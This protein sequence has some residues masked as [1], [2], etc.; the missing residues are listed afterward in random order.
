MD[1]QKLLEKMS[2]EDK[3]AQMLQITPEM[4]T[5]KSEGMVTGPMT[6]F[7]IPENVTSRV[8]SVL[9]GT[10]AETLRELQKL[11]LKE[12]P[13]GIPLLFMADV[14]H[15]FRT[16][17]PTPLGI[18]ATFDEDLAEECSAMAAKE[19]AASGLHV[20]FAPMMDLARDARWGRC[21]ETCGE[22]PHLNSKMAAAMV[23]GFQGD[24]GSDRVAAC[25]KHFAAYSACEGGRDYD[26]AEVC[27]HT[28]REYYLPAYKAAIDA[29]VELAMTSF[30]TLNGVPSSANK[31]LVDG[32]LRKEWGFDGIVISDYGALREMMPHGISENEKESAQKALDATTDIE[33][34]TAC[35]VKYGKELLDEGKITLEQIDTAV[36]RILKLKEKLGL[37]D[38]PFRSSSPEEEKRLFLCKEH[39]DIAR[40]AAQKS[41]VLLKNEDVLPFDD[42]VKKVA[43]IGPFANRGMIGAWYC[44][45]REDEAVSVFEG[46]KKERPDAVFSLGCN[47]GLKE[48]SSDAKESIEHAV[49]LAKDSD[50][51]IICAGEANDV[52]GEAHSR[53]RLSLSD[54]QTHLIKEVCKVNKKTVLLLF[55]G[56]PLALENIN[57]ISPCT[58]VFWQP[59]TEGGTAIS[60]LIFGKANFE[61]KLPMCFPYEGQCPVYYNYLRTGRPHNPYGRY[62]VRYE[63][64]PYYPLYSFGYGLSYT[65]FEISE[66][67]LSSDTMTSSE[68]ITVSVNIKNTGKYTGTET[69]QM[70]INDVSASVCRPVKELKG[71][72]K[73]TLTPNEEAKA[74]FKITEDELKFHTQSGKFEAEKGL[75]RVFVGSSSLVNDFKEFKLV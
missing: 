59:G 47:G 42:T 36:M 4:I 56:R 67:V 65:S 27:E 16:I 60:E 44:N 45:G 49:Q 28:L 64:I 13:N 20:T 14:I 35:F 40:L 5:D 29:N 63:D 46:I 72:K 7:G 19:A 38:D 62:C 26:N 6:K 61:G 43:V 54:A 23:K 11:H 24:L 31:A 70:Y 41:A 74:E 34:M 10:G 3:L 69:L 52:S 8:G 50:A 2:L 1:I 18:G 53:A 48:S 68:E 51:V 12:D 75:F 17:Y 21:T 55:C 9:G 22:D 15:G 32:I 66:P 71:Y 57:D 58:V 33:M 39:R 30:N 73:I 37:F 25:I